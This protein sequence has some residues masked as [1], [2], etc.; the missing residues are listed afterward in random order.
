MD[1]RTRREL[2]GL[3][4]TSSIAALAGCM[5]SEGAPNPGTSTP[6][7]SNA[8]PSHGEKI[9]PTN[10]D[11]GDWFGNS[12]SIS[13]NGEIAVI[14]VS[15]DNGHRGEAIGFAYVYANQSDGWS[16]KAN[17]VSDEGSSGGL[18]GFSVAV[19]HDGE[20]LRASLAEVSTGLCAEFGRLDA[21]PSELEYPRTFRRRR[22]WIRPTPAAVRGVRPVPRRRQ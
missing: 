22:R 10:G 13:G 17:I 3:A 16:L 7:Q 4:G 20:R 5:N 2:L 21:S 6:S 14:G 8:T 18:F 11:P 12:V 15:Q 19:S 9:T 1:F